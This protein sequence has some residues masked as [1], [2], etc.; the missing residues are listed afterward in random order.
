MLFDYPRFVE[1]K[2]SFLDFMK[3]PVGGG[4]GRAALPHA[5]GRTDITS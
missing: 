5:G 2:V 3:I 4:E 1:S